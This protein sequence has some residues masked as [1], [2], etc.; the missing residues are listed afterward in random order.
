MARLSFSPN[1]I[2]LL[3]AGSVFVPFDAPAQEAE[4]MLEEVVVTAARESAPLTVVTDPRQPHQPLPASD[5]ADYLKTIPGFSVI[6]KGGSDGDPV[7]RGMAGSR[8]SILLDGELLFGG[9][10]GRMDPPTAYVTPSSYDEVT[11][12]KGPQS[13]RFG[14]GNVAGVVGFERK[15]QALVGPGAS[16]FG[17]GLLGSF[18]R[19][20]AVFDTKVGNER[21]Y[22]RAVGTY[23]H[24]D[25]YQDGNGTRVHSSYERWSTNAAVGWT[26]GRDTL[27]EIAGTAG[28]GRAAYADRGMDGTA[29][30]RENVGLRFEKGDL[31]PW[32]KRVEGQLYYNYIDHVM[33][34]YR[35]RD[36]VPTPMSPTPRVSNPDRRTE[37]GRLAL[38]VAPADAWQ[39][40]AG[41]DGQRNTHRFRGSGNAWSAPYQD[42]PRIDNARF[43][44][45]GMFGELTTYLPGERR[46]I[47]GARADRWRARD[48]RATPGLASAGGERTQTLFSGFARYEQ[49]V[50]RDRTRL[51]P[52]VGIGHAERFPDYWE[53]IT[54]QGPDSNSAFFTRPE[55]NTQLDAGLLWRRDEQLSAGV[56]LFYGRVSDYILIDSRAFGKAPGTVV[57]RNINATLW[58]GE[59]SFLWGMASHWK[60]GGSLAY[61][62]GSNDTDGTPLAQVP[63][64]ES[65]LSLTYENQHVSVTGLVRAVAAQSRVDPGRGNI[66]G[67]DIGRSP[68]FA[69]LALNAS[70]RPHKKV[71][72]SAGID[73]LLNR[74]YAEHLNRRAAPVAGYASQLGRINEPGRSVWAKVDVTLE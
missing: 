56:S 30:R 2:C 8:L 42:Y 36:F 19:R 3:A 13:V 50:Q 9:C 59:A 67:Q 69:T 49:D 28:D 66:A 20:D 16:L 33:D 55:R 29:F 53:L 45:Y 25:D 34:N 46:L 10:G 14:P 72:L 43:S 40:I 37:G 26:P 6:R 71:L 11:V 17:S 21:V 27:V 22:V 58:G 61:T 32:L 44:N 48:A 35:M 47:G 38:T 1:R 73:N 4:S 74:T 65:R 68:G 31:T 62:R 5:G 7:F 51:T 57:S 41:I 18:G 23:S 63:P 52:Y 12:V 39:L 70:Y 54:K 15:R 24:S 60:L 64:L